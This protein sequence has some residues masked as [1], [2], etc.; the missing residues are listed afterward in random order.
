MDRMAVQQGVAIRV[1]H[2][3]VAR[4]RRI[5]PR[6]RSSQRLRSADPFVRNLPG[7]LVMVLAVG[8]CSSAQTRSAS[9]QGKHLVAGERNPRTVIWCFSGKRDEPESLAHALRSKLITHV[10]FFVGNRRTS[11]TLH[12]SQTRTAIAM[13]KAASDPA[14]ELILVR[15]LWQT[16]PSPQSQLS[17]L[18]DVDYYLGEIE[19]LRKEARQIGARYVALDTETYGPTP[20]T[21][22]F[23]SKRFARDGY[24]KLVLTVQE[25][26]R[27]AGKV[28]FVLPAGSGRRNHPYIALAG[29]GKQRISEG[30]Y[31]DNAKS[32]RAIRYPYEI[33]G[34]YMNVTKKNERHPWNRFFL[35]QDVFGDRASVWQEK[36][37]LMIWPRENRAGEVAR[38][39]EDF[40]RQRRERQDGHPPSEP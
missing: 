37:G 13:A 8:V 24:E 22:H 1:T 2:G 4:A 21:A 7:A 30:T 18:S 19:L 15:F 6:I 33:S 26:V 12:K 38:L 28:D 20:L 11:D 10:A 34:M 32:I 9:A 14:V 3:G 17:A 29:L 39:M 5:F 36:E 35:P 23:R 27:K 40:A 16:Q 31:Y 25:V